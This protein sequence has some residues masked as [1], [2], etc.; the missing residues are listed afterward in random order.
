MDYYLKDS[1]R[2]IIRPQIIKLISKSDLMDE[3][4]LPVTIGSFTW[5]SDDKESIFIDLVNYNIDID[6]D[7]I[8]TAKELSFKIKLPE[9][10]LKKRISLTTISPDINCRAYIEDLQHTDWLSVAINTIEH[11]VSIK[12]KAE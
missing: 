1:E 12:I 8:K 4:N 7:K 10:M 3:G 11:F 5:I 2:D 9:T 6:K